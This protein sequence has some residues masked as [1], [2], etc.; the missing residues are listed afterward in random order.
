MPTPPLTP[1]QFSVLVE[2]AR[3]DSQLIGSPDHGEGHW[4][5]VANVGLQLAAADARVDPHGIVLFAL[6]HDCR[7]ISEG[8]DPA[9]GDRGAAVLAAGFRALGIPELPPAVQTVH[10]ACELH[11]GG[12]VERDDA[13]IGACCDAD[14][15]LL[16]RVGITPDPAY[17]FTDL[18]KRHAVEGGLVTTAS[19]ERSWLDLWSAATDAAG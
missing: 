18:A 7:R 9:H 8:H 17:L 15:L 13:T 3:T 14:R 1:E 10:R 11:H 2:L 16:P 5:D 6:H 19:D 4:L 12:H